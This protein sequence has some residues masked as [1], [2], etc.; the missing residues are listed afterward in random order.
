MNKIKIQK[1]FKFRIMFKKWYAK[2]EDSRSCEISSEEISLLE[3][4]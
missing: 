2:W 4:S 3:K 1:I